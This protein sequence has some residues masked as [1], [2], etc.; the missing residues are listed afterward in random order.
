MTEK[1]RKEADLYQPIQKHFTNLG[2]KVNG[3]VNDCDLTAVKGDELIIVELKLS[4]TIDL[5]I[6]AAK[7]QRLTDL[8]YIAIPKPKRT[9]SRRWN[10][11][12]HLVK[13]L[14]LGLITVSLTKRPKIEFVAHPQPFDRK[15]VMTYS[16]RKRANLIKEIEGRSADYNTGGSNKTKIMT[17]YKES[18]IQIACCLEKHGPLSPKALKELGTGD[19]TP[20]ILQKNYYKWFDRVKRG[21]YQLNETGKREL[22]KYPEL[23]SYYEGKMKDQ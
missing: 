14:E 5:L 20:S 13:R 10:D 6:Q 3:E 9:R 21:V 22:E 11:I 2:Y 4:L 1:K 12:C 23:V 18:C 8:V 16:K 19:K 17:A 15:K 7:R